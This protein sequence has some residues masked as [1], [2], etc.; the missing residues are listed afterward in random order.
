MQIVKFN[1]HESRRMMHPHLRRGALM[2]DPHS[3]VGLYQALNLIGMSWS[4]YT[5]QVLLF[6]HS[7][8]QY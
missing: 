4:L 6:M 8:K 7:G 3:S 5:F 1:C 2:D